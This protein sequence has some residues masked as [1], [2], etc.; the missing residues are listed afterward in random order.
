MPTD[1]APMPCRIKACA[2]SAR[3]S[4]AANRLI[5][6]L[7][8]GT[9]RGCRRGEKDSKVALREFTTTHSSVGDERRLALLSPATQT[10]QQEG[11]ARSM[12]IQRYSRPAMILHWAIAFCIVFNVMLA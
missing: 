8:T 12:D 2:S 11:Q 10:C 9:A 4:A 5:A 6:R 1:Q 3:N 7:A